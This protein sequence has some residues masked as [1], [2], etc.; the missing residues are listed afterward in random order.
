MLHCNA[1]TQNPAKLCVSGPSWLC[2]GSKAMRLEL[3]P[4]AATSSSVHLWY[5]AASHCTSLKL[6]HTTGAH[7]SGSLHLGT[8]QHCRASRRNLGAMQSVRGL[9]GKRGPP[10]RAQAHA[11]E[12]PNGPPRQ[13]REVLV[14]NP[15]DSHYIYQGAPAGRREQCRSG[16]L[17]LRLRPAAWL[18]SCPWQPPWPRPGHLRAAS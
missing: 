6:W 16:N 5:A 7:F 2:R 10:N 12:L 14:L 13:P 11:L 1:F 3:S 8:S 15:Q 18:L 4:G 17:A 9:N